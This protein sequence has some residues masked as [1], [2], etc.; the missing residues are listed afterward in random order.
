[1]SCPS[2]KTRY[3]DRIAANAAL[4]IRQQSQQ[5]AEEC[6][7]CGGV[8][9]PEQNQQQPGRQGERDQ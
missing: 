9:L 3:R 2:G 7:R 8:H 4:P 5:A 1:M 6:D